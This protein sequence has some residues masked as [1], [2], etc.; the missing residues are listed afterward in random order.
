MA[1]STFV[2]YIESPPVAWIPSGRGTPFPVTA[3]ST[4]VAP[5]LL[6]VMSA[7]YAPGAV[8]EK[9]TYTVVGARVP[10]V[11]VKFNDD[12]NPDPLLVETWKFAGAFTDTLAVRLLPDTV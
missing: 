11:C 9:R 4:F 12:P 8:G 3:S 6:L 10:P 7:A 1:P 2:T 5:A